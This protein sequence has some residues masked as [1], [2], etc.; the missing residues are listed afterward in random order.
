LLRW[1]CG[2]FVFCTK[3]ACVQRDGRIFRKHVCR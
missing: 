3:E 2:C 1:A